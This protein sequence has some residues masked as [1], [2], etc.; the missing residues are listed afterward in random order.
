MKIGK[1]QKDTTDT[2]GILKN[3]YKKLYANKTDNLQKYGKVL[4]YKLPILN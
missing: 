4:R 3:C 1:L 2:E